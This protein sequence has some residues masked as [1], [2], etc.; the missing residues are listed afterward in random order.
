M[1][2]ER[3]REERVEMEAVTAL[4]RAREEVNRVREEQGFTA[5]GY[6]LQEL[7]EPT[8]YDPRSP[9][10]MLRDAVEAEKTPRH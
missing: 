6:Y 3:N 9:T 1:R 10:R 5:T 7:H 2:D 4:L 8:P